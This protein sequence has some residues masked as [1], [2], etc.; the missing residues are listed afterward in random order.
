[1]KFVLCFHP[2]QMFKSQ[3]ILRFGKLAGNL[4]DWPCL[5][6]KPLNL[7]KD[8][9][10]MFF[11]SGTAKFYVTSWKNIACSRPRDSWVQEIETTKIKWEET[12]GGVESCIESCER[13]SLDMRCMVLGVTLK[14]NRQRVV[15]IEKLI[16]WKID[17]IQWS[18]YW[19]PLLT[20]RLMTLLGNIGPRS[21]CSTDL[22]AFHS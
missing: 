3:V 16:N 17:A 7:Q 8:T 5:H 20:T 21:F 13:G 19:C 2:V 14:A 10:R 1:M 9:L 12:G 11:L 4:L 22:S 15:F 6:T 18:C